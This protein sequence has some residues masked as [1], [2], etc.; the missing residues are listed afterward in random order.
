MPT[1]PGGLY[2]SSRLDVTQ[3][4]DI[5]SALVG[6][7]I[8]GRYQLERLISSGGMGFVF[9]ATQLSVN[10][11]VAVKLLRPE[12]A[13]ELDL[14]QRFAQ[15]VEAIATLSHP[16]IVT[17]IDAGRDQG[18]LAYL[19][20]EFV[21]GETFRQSLQSGALSLMDLLK[22]FAQVCEALHMAHDH[23]VIHRDLKFDNIMITRRPGGAVHARV[24]DFGVAKMLRRDLN[25]TRGGQLPGTPGIIAPE[26]ANQSAPSPQSDLYSIGVLLYTVLCG[27]P[28][29]RGHNDLA[30][31]HAHQ[32]E[33][34]PRL[35]DRVHPY[36]PEQVIQ[37]VYQMLEKS[38]ADRPA[39]A[40]MV[41]DRLETEI[42]ALSR[43]TGH[44]ERAYVPPAFMGGVLAMPEQEADTDIDELTLR[45]VL[46]QQEQE[47]EREQAQAKSPLIGPILV[48]SS[49]VVMLSLLLLSLIVV[50]ITL[51]TRTIGS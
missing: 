12:L 50:L 38:P 48:P 11:R 33:A 20:M 39:D 31:M 15:E 40:L 13:G 17:L 36:V 25:L 22:V 46:S 35:E 43:H 28:P 7:V 5:P 41:R 49:V 9:E 42:V 21:R 14:M 18:G 16:H 4:L 47:R 1:R 27:S 30:L 8:E 2:Q 29:F 32:Y 34:L 45:F 51:L 23:D 6:R 19:V 24:L 44:H 26:L 37:L 10:R 3:P